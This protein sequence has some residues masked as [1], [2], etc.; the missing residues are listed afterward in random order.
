MKIN[1]HSS[2]VP[3]YED[4]TVCSEKLVYKFHTPGNYPEESIQQE[5]YLSIR[6]FEA[7]LDIHWLSP[8]V[9]HFLTLST[10]FD[11][12]DD[13]VKWRGSGIKPHKSGHAYNKAIGYISTLLSTCP[14]VLLIAISNAIWIGNR[15][16]HS[17]K[18]I[19][20]SDGYWWMLGIRTVFL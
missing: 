13:A 1:S 8:S 5:I 2:Y 11:N 3:A 18:G 9:C 6:N 20:G 10:P 7:L 16:L 17:L 14:W 4:G 15:L 19:V 12:C